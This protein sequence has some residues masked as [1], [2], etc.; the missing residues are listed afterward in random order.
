MKVIKSILQMQDFARGQIVSGRTVG[1]VPTM[2]ALHEGHLSLVRRSSAENDVTVVSIFVNPT[3]FGPGEDFEC[4]PRDLDADLA[5]LQGLKTDIVFAPDASSMYPEGA[6]TTVH[7]GRTGNVLCGASRPGHFDGVATVVLKLF[8]IVKPSM[9]CFGQKDFQQTV[10]IKSMVRDLD[11]DVDIVVCPI[12][13]EPDG[14]AM[15]SRNH[16]LS[17]QERQAATVLFRA[18]EAG[19][20]MIMSGE[21]DMSVVKHS[22]QQVIESEPLAV[23]DYIEIVRPDDL[24]LARHLDNDLAL[25]IAVRIGNTR[26]IDNIIVRKG[27]PLQA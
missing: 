3:Q 9:A 2:G 27:P 19:K 7:V 14:L 16:Y 18:L 25:L 24:S 12:V 17:G 26:L 13:R 6:M 22:M 4:Y 10:V 8:H 1:F 11:L 23:T 15:S 21:Q 5:R 20:A